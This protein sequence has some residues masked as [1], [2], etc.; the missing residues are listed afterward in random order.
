[1]EVRGQVHGK[2]AAFSG[3]AAP[4]PMQLEAG[5]FPKKGSNIFKRFIII[6]SS[7]SIIISISSNNHREE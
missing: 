7:I 1:M 4:T 3:K 2:S 5:W 6:S